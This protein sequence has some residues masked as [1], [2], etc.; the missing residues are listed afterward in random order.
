MYTFL[1]NTINERPLSPLQIIIESSFLKLLRALSSSPVIFI[2]IRLRLERD[3]KSFVVTANVADGGCLPSPPMRYHTREV[4]IVDPRDKQILNH[5]NNKKKFENGS[6]YLSE[7]DESKDAFI[8]NQK[9][10]HQDLSGF[11][12][13]NR[14]TDI[15]QSTTK[16]GGVSIRKS[17]EQ[18]GITAQSIRKTEQQ[19]TSIIGPSIRKS[20]RLTDSID[21][22]SIQKYGLQ[23]ESIRKSGEKPETIGSP[24]SIQKSDKM[25]ELLSSQS[26]RRSEQVPV[27][28][29]SQSTR[30]SKEPNQSF[31]AQ[32]FRK[33]N[34]QSEFQDKQSYRQSNMPDRSLA[35]QSVLK[36]NIQHMSEM[37]PNDVGSIRKSNTIGQSFGKVS[38][39]RQMQQYDDMENNY[40]EIPNLISLTPDDIDISDSIN[41]Y[42][43]RAEVDVLGSARRTVTRID[44]RVDYSPTPPNSLRHSSLEL[45]DSSS[46]DYVEMSRGV[47]NKQHLSCHRPHNDSS[48]NDKKGRCRCKCNCK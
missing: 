15:K 39:L 38:D 32:S 25:L 41:R 28:I 21:P 27:R 10:T 31:G 42:S 24:K 1:S 8:S 16:S 4:V 46:P 26:I 20:D 34:Q 37:N 3:W 13:S 44:N 14:I 19:D 2:W 6:T 23:S 40:K 48:A 35:P 22:Q 18:P 36:S 17:N 30:M 33:S 43:K 9:I 47:N 12:K 29:D 5:V 11:T 7:E 45:N